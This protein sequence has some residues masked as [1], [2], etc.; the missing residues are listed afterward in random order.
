MEIKNEQY[1]NEDD[2]MKKLKYIDV[3]VDDLISADSY[4]EQDLINN[5]SKN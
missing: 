3:K 5:F 1:L 4:N 2:L